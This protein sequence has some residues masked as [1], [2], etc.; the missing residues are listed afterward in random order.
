[1][2]FVPSHCVQHSKGHKCP[3]KIETFL[4]SMTAFT[5]HNNFALLYF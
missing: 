4:V 2:S 3:E 5:Q 1:M